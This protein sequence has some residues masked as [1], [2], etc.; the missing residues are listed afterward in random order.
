MIFGY[1]FAV[2]VGFLFTPGMLWA[3][4]FVLFIV[5]WPVLLKPRLDGRGG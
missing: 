1:A 5:E 2:I 3:S 4:A